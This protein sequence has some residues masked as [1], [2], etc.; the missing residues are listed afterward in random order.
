MRRF[1]EHKKS[2]DYASLNSGIGEQTKEK[3]DYR[4]KGEKKCGE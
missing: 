3:T 1:D 4:K 2:L